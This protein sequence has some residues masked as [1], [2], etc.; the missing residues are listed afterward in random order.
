VNSIAFSNNCFQLAAGYNNGFLRVWDLKEQNVVFSSSMQ[1]S[2]ISAIAWDSSFKYLAYANSL[3]DI[4]ILDYKRKSIYASHSQKTYNGVKALKF[5]PHNKNMLF[6]AGAD[7]CLS[8]YNIESS[9]LKPRTW[10]LHQNKCTM[11]DFSSMSQYLAITAGLDQIINILDIREKGVS[12]TM[13]LSVPI[14]AG[15]VAPNGY[16][17][18]VGSY[19]GD[20]IGLDLRKPGVEVMRYKGHLKNMISS[21]DFVHQVKEKTANSLDK[22]PERSKKSGNNQQEPSPR[23]EV[24]KSRIKRR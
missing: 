22:S 18:I 12:K 10:H 11:I 1:Y 15:A 3:G 8:I 23:T 20:L 17:L 14:T 21:I 24:N 13:N 5:S 16:G 4:Q 2:E 19:F 6:S 9:E 7:G